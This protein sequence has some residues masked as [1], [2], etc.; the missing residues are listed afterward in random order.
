MS[1]DQPK[2]NTANQASHQSPVW[3]QTGEPAL[4]TLFCELTGDSEQQARNAF[5]FVSSDNEVSK[6]P[7][8]D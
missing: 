2:E 1:A 7:P 3:S 5:M 8:S 6:D 4:V